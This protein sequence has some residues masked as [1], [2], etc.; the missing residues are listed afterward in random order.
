MH[1]DVRQYINSCN[2]CQ[3]TKTIR[4][5]PRGMLAPNRIPEHLWQ[6][7]SVDL[8]TELPTSQGYD[9]ILVIVDLFTKMIHLVP[10]YTTL[11]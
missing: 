9:A 5:K 6:C 10:T 3:R 4:A 1:T 2:I 8:I 7:I 11:I